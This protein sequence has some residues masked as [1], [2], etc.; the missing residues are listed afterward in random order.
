MIEIE[1]KAYLKRQETL[2]KIKEIA[3][4]VKVSEKKDIYFAP[5]AFKRENLYKEALF[6]I[7]RKGDEQI[8]S[9]K[10][11]QVKDKTEINDEHEIDV[12]S[13]NLAELRDFFQHIGFFP[14]I[15]K[16][17]KTNL[18]KYSKNKDFD[19]L[20]EHNL[21]EDLGEFIEIEILTEDSSQIENAS[22]IISKL[23]QEIGILESE[24]E[25]RYYIDLL[26]EKKT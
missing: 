6:R 5:I 8:L 7:R 26:M 10:K 14:F 9:Y 21:I 12:S 2:Q 17:K 11:K 18:Y 15:E 16:T 1:K 13:Q 25:P 19:V 23:F 20:I 24:I 3:S 22:N 4:F